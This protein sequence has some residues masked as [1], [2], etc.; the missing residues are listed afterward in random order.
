[1]EI[2]KTVWD[3]LAQMNFNFFGVDINF[4]ELFVGF[5]VLSLGIKFI[6]GLFNN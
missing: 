1:M 5:F 2:V 4:I 6:Y 3:G